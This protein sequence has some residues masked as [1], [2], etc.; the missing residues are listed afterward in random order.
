MERETEGGGGQRVRKREKRIY[1]FTILVQSTLNV[2]V[3]VIYYT[4]ISVLSLDLPVV[5]VEW[6]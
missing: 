3:H 2:A 4:S 6:L 1:F 5:V